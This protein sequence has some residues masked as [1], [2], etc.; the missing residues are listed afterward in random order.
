MFGSHY[1]FVRIFSLRTYQFRPEH[2]KVKREDLIQ[3]YEQVKQREKNAYHICPY[4]AEISG[5][6]NTKFPYRGNVIRRDIEEGLA[7]KEPIL[8]RDKFDR[9]VFSL[10]RFV[11]HGVVLSAQHGVDAS[12]VLHEK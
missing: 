2:P 1:K 4:C 6:R 5:L 9:G 8:L 3:H 12:A 11:G 10:S 7:S